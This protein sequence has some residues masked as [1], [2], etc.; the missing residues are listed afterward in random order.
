MSE[1]VSPN[2]IEGIVGVSR[3]PVLHYARAISEEEMV[4]ILHSQVCFDSGRDLRDC[5]ASLALSRGI[6]LETWA[7]YTDIPVPVVVA[8]GRLVPQS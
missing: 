2:E 1:L 7:D 5:P 3:D 6:D 8:G 4:Y